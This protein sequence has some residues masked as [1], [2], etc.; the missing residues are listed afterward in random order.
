MALR[1]LDADRVDR[2]GAL[3]GGMSGDSGDGDPYMAVVRSNVNKSLSSRMSER[4]FA[5]MTPSEVTSARMTK[6]SYINLREGQHASQAYARDHIKGWKLDTQLSDEHGSVFQHERTGELRVAYRG[7]QAGRDWETNLR[8]GAGLEKGGTQFKAL[9]EQMQ[10]VIRKYGRKPDLLTGHSK[11]GG[12]AIRMGENH[13]INTH[14]QDPYVPTRLM[15]SAGGKAKAK[16]T[17]IRTP[18]DWV[19]ANSNISKFRTGFTQKDIAPT[20]GTSLLQSHDLNLM[21][22]VEHEAT[23]N[24]DYDPVGKNKAFMA[25]EIA[26]GRSFAQVADTVGYDRGSSDYQQLRS[27]Y[28]EARSTPLNER[29]THLRRAGFVSE[30]PAGSVGS[31]AMR[32]GSALTGQFGEGVSKVANVGTGGAILGGLG[33][34]AALRTVG[35]NDEAT[36]AIASGAA[37]NA[38]A[39]AV[40]AAARAASGAT[41]TAGA[42]T[43]AGALSSAARSLVRGGAGG[44]LGYGVERAVSQLGHLAGVNDTV[45]D[46]AAAGAGGAAAGAVFGP[47]GAAIGG[48][49]GAGIAGATSI[50]Q[51]TQPK[52]DYMLSPFRHSEIDSSIGSNPE[53]RAILSD[54]NSRAD[55]RDDA[56]AEVEGKIT[57]LVRELQRQSGWTH[58]YERYTASLEEVPRGAQGQARDGRGRPTAM[59]PGDYT[60]IENQEAA[61]HEAAMQEYQQMA[62]ASDDRLHNS[63]TGLSQFLPSLLETDEQF[64]NAT[65]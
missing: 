20:A 1:A 13:G 43:G 27:E 2:A 33:A 54:F 64:L 21:T 25:R 46:I 37:G 34:V 40:T 18:T 50:F 5:K 22:G 9:E 3:T 4:E 45:T 32:I 53:I 41:R 35:V 23:G 24:T 7:T 38:S 55:F 65:S 31:A 14:T 16:H 6:A 52:K 48:V 62:D 56:I 10:S 42:M 61:V 47:E 39:D 44:V 49:L 29:D 19:S 28:E 57:T 63:T 12:Q 17:V 60:E 15:T 11:G 8:M 58:G 51:A 30:V 59:L 36:L 26:K